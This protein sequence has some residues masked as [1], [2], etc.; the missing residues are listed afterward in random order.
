MIKGFIV[1]VYENSNEVYSKTFPSRAKVASFLR[2][3]GIKFRDSALCNLGDT[4]ITFKDTEG[5]IYEVEED[6]D[7]LEKIRIGNDIYLRLQE[8]CEQTG[9]NRDAVYKSFKR[10]CIRG[11]HF[12][13]Y[14]LV[15]I[16]WESLR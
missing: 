9:K 14:N 5:W 15:Y 10:G 16:Y 3:Q 7:K 6:I 4:S 8:Y 12:G 11:T 2:K 1:H 13:R